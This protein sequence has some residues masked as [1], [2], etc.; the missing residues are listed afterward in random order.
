MTLA[1]PYLHIDYRFTGTLLRC[2]LIQH[3][4]LDGTSTVPTLT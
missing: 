2:A 1:A 3:E 4:M